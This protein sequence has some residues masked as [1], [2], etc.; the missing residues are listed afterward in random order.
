MNVTAEGVFFSN[1]EIETMSSD[2]LF[3]NAKSE[4][5]FFNELVNLWNNGSYFNYT[6]ETTRQMGDAFFIRINKD[7]SEDLVEL[8]YNKKESWF[9]LVKRVTGPGGANLWKDVIRRGF[10]LQT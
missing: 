1:E 3:L 10:K 9:S 5:A 4:I 2:D 8:H 6:N 7:G